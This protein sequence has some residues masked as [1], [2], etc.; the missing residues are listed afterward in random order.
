MRFANLPFYY[1][2]LAAQHFTQETK[3]GEKQYSQIG[4]VDY[5]NNFGRVGDREFCKY[6]ITSIIQN[7]G[8]RM[9]TNQS[10]EKR[11]KNLTMHHN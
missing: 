6:H 11:K 10:G 4:G 8:G 5:V 1:Y 7:Y 9:D 2:F 3:D